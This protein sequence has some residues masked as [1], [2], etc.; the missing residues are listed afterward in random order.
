MIEPFFFYWPGNHWVPNTC[1]AVCMHAQSLQLCPTLC[2]TMDYKSARLLSPWDSPGKNTG[3]GCHALLQGIFLTQGSNPSPLH[4]RE[5]LHLWDTGEA[6]LEVCLQPKTP[7]LKNS[8]SSPEQLLSV[9]SVS[10]AWEA[11]ASW[12]VSLSPGCPWLPNS[13]QT[14]EMSF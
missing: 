2:D 6:C 5:I 9:L 8:P 11:S 13:I 3:M 7:R 1:L 10:L 14:P 4:Y 12:P